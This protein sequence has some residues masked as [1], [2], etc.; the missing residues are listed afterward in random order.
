ME[1]SAVGVAESFTTW[2]QAG[3][4]EDTGTERAETA[5]AVEELAPSTTVLVGTAEPIATGRPVPEGDRSPEGSGVGGTGGGRKVAGH[6]LGLGAG[7]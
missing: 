6:R 2:L 3:S 7:C 5:G 4:T 1:L